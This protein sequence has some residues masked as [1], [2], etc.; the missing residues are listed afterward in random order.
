MKAGTSLGSSQ[1][2]SAHMVAQVTCLIPLFPTTEEGVTAFF[3]YL[4]MLPHNMEPAAIRLASGIDHPVMGATICEEAH[5]VDFDALA[6]TTYRLLLSAREDKKATL[7]D[8]KA[9]YARLQ[10]DLR[11]LDKTI[12]NPYASEPK[13]P[14]TPYTVVLTGIL[15]LMVFLTVSISTYVISE[16][17]REE[18]ILLGRRYDFWVSLAVIL[19]A[20]LSPKALH[21]TLQT[22]GARRM[23]LRTLM[24]GG[25]SFCL[26]CVMVLMLKASGVLEAGS[27]Q[28]GWDAVP[29]ATPFLTEGVVDLTRRILQVIGETCFGAWA[30]I[31]GEEM[32]R[33][34]GQME[35]HR[36]PNPEW[37]AMQEKIEHAAHR[38][39][40]CQAVCHRFGSLEEEYERARRHYVD[41]GRERYKALHFAMTNTWPFDS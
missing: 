34:H 24:A 9:E 10:Q 32:L 30:F 28:P 17:L 35:P 27:M 29:R 40:E 33:R 11:G 19:G 21:S 18:T 26:L 13:L 41:R 15:F 7:V 37:S 4:P 31:M 36:L 1:G 3:N 12:P 14:W 23:Y 38:I 39:R 6:G 20:T 25:I 2:R 22:P 16:I 5:K 8:A